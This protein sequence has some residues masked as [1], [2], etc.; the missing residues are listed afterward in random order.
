MGWWA[1][2]S[3]YGEKLIVGDDPLDIIVG[4]LRAVSQAY[5][6]DYGRKPTL[7][8]VLNVIEICLGSEASEL[9]LDFDERELINIRAKTRRRRKKQA[10]KVGDYFAVPLGEDGYGFGRIIDNHPRYGILILLFNIISNR[11]LQAEELERAPQ[12]FPPIYAGI[13]EAWTTWRWK[14]IEGPPV[15]KG[16]YPIPR[17]RIQGHLPGEGWRIREG[18]QIYAATEDEVRGLETMALWPPEP[19]ENRMRKELGVKNDS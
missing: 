6:E 18:E 15:I 5:R 10:Y 12:L 17:F 11:M 19:I 7:D 14:I 13:D 9:L 1:E 16:E 8:E 4:M 2:D 3:P